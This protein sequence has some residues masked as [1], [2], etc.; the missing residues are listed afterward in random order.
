[1]S[2]TKT[3]VT[4]GHLQKW[5]TR[6]DGGGAGGGSNCTVH[7]NEIRIKEFITGLQT[8]TARRQLPLSPAR[9]IKIIFSIWNA[10]TDL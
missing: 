7:N 10:G 2:F 9:E 5:D 1:M 8:G 4:F 3:H 6:T